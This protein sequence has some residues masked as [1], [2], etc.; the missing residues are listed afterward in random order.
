MEINLKLMPDE[1][2]FV[3][4]LDT[5]RRLVGKLNYLTITR[6]NISYTVS[7][8]SRFM[9]NPQVPHMN[10]VIRIPKYLKNA[11][12]HGLFY[13]SFG[14]LCIKGYT[15]TDWTGSPLDRKS[16]TSYCT[17]IGS[18]LITWRSKKQLVIAHSAEAE[19]RAMAHTACK[20]IRLRTI[21]QQFG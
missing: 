19:Y 13:R 20:R 1:S 2:D 15:N 12:S 8:V 3:D 16:I 4:D 6:P 5:Y 11:P 9:T 21:L 7:I 17:F 10:A 18:D 14:H